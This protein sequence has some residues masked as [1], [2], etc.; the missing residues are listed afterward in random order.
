[1][2]DANPSSPGRSVPSKKSSAAAPPPGREFLRNDRGQPVL[3]ENRPNGLVIDTV[4][5]EG[6]YGDK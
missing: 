6:D 1:M 4:V 2:A 5:F 3:R